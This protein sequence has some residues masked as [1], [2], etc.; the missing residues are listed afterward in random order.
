MYTYEKTILTTYKQTEAFIK[1]TRLAMQRGVYSSYYSRRPTVDL[2]E[3]ILDLKMQLEEIEELKNAI[4]ESLAEIKP[5][6][7]YLLKVR[8]G[9]EDGE[10]EK[11]EKDSKFYRMV[12]YALQKFVAAWAFAAAAV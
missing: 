4:D 7:A 10:Q 9:I 2:A 8:F 6:Y 3:E 5:C 12:A 1:S 11:T